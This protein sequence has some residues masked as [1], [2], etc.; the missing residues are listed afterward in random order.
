M[1]VGSL[2]YQAMVSVFRALVR[3][4]ASFG[5]LLFALGCLI[6]LMSLREEQPEAAVGWQVATEWHEAGEGMNDELKG[7]EGLAEVQ[8]P[9]VGDA[10][11]GK[12]LK[13]QEEPARRERPLVVVDAGHGGGD[14]GAVWNGI[15]EKNLALTLALKLKAQLEKMGIEVQM[16]RSK[17]VFVSLENRAAVANRAKADVFVSVHL[18]SAGNEAGVRGIETYYCTNKSLGAVRAMQAAFKLKTTVGLRDRRGEKLA[19]VV[20]RSVCQGTSG[21]DRGTKERAYTVV[22]G[23]SCPAV[24]V[25]CGFISNS[26]EAAL[27]KTRAYQEKL[28]GGI[29]RGIASFLHGQEMDPS[30]GLEL[31]KGEEPVLHGPLIKPELLSLK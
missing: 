4:L 27:L 11:E 15:V 21:L 25:E 9:V 16:T 26:K 24:L 30:R 17:D 1:R 12:G 13:E 18:N 7:G 5:G 8:E 19:S 22:H 3:N 2:Y 31:P 23:A 10:A 14:G 6:W 29:A 20:Q 28:A